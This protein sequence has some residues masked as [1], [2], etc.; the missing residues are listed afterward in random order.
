M[1][2]RENPSILLA[3]RSLVVRCLLHGQNQNR[4]DGRQDNII[5][6]EG[7]LCLR[8]LKVDSSANPWIM[9]VGACSMQQDAFS[10]L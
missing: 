6:I 2:S 3:V 1:T 7:L 8:Q 9:S 4:S 5:V 10:S